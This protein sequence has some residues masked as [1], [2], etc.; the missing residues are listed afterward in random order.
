LVSA[1]QDEVWGALTDPALL[2]DCT[3]FVRRI[4]AVDDTHWYWELASLDVLGLKVSRSFTE[5]MTFTPKERIDFRHE[6]PAG[7]TEKAGVAGWYALTPEGE[8]TRLETEM[9]ITVDLPLPRAAGGAVR[10]TMGR[11]L[12][13]MG[14]RFSRSL[15]E[16]LHA[17]RL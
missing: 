1:T 5:R 13:Q 14:E 10:A 16:H 4:A 7:E 15:L 12:D 17:R 3:P 11:V 6:P 2:A 8:G 9:S